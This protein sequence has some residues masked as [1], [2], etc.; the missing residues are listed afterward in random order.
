MGFNEAAGYGAVAVTALAT[1]VIAARY[2][3]RPEPFFLGVAY[4]ALGL[5]LSTLFVRETHGHARHEATTHVA[6]SAEVHEGLSTKRGV[7]PHQLQGEGPL[8][9]RARPAWSTTSTTASPGASS[10]STSPPH[11][12]SVGRI[13]VL[14]ALYPAV[15]G[16]G[17]LVTG[18]LSD[19]IGRKRLIVAGMFDPGGRHRAHRRGARLLD[20]GRRRRRC[21]A[22][23]PRWCIRRCSPPSA[24]SPIPRGG[25][26]R[27]AST[28]SGATAGSPSAPSSPA[29]SPTR[30]AS[31]PPSGPWPP[32]PP[33]PGFVVA[34]RMYE[35]HPRGDSRAVVRASA[36]A[37]L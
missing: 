30:S 13:G 2:G 15:W 16:L 33:R 25:R 20:V 1:G 29:S 7:P 11:G 32:S 19:R 36:P 27:S 4:A 5:G 24:T 34:V 26:P 14:A 8:G 22:R 6:A 35:T 37:S 12:L 17:Q 31:R 21:S 3:L 9:A 10:R 23:A 28:D 18:A